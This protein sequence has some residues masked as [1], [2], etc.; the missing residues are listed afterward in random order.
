MQS[1][2]NAMKIAKMI[3]C[4]SIHKDELGRWM[5][6]SSPLEL[7]RIS[8]KAEPKQK[9][10]I[11]K[12]DLSQRFIKGQKNSKRKI[13]GSKFEKLKERGIAGISTGPDGSLSSMKP[14]SPGALF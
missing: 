13:R 14:G 3:G 5:P 1:R 11:R 8:G 4:S 6:C 7:E 10:D 9:F 2:D 12:T